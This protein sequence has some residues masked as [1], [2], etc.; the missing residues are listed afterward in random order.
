M[1]GGGGREHALV[2]ALRR[3]P[4]AP[5]VLCAPGSAGIAREGVRCLDVGTGDLEG[6]V[7][8]A[9]EEDCD[10]VVIGPE[11]PLVDGLVD[12]LADG[13]VRAFGPTGAA[14]RIE[15]SKAYAK[16]VMEAA[17][18]ATPGHVVLGDHEAALAAIEDAAYPLVLKADMLAGGKGVV[19]CAN[20]AEAG[21]ALDDFFGERR[22]GDTVVVLEEFVDGE[23]ISLLAL[24]DGERALPMA[25]ARDFKRIGDGDRGSNTGGMGSYSPVA[26]IDAERAEELARSV[27]QPVLDELRGRGTPYHGV[28]Y[29]G[30]M[31]TLG[32]PQVLEF[33]CRF[34]DPET[35][36]ILPRLRSDLLEL[37]EAAVRPGGLEGFE[38]EW[39]PDP[40]VTVV[41][42]SRGYPA[43]SSSG[44]RISGIDEAAAAPDVEVLHAGTADDGTGGYVT[45]GG[46]V[47]D[48]T[49]VGATLAEARSRAYAAADRIEF[50]GRQLRRDIAAEAGEPVGA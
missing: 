23:E 15:G 18:V 17:G 10:L 20:R 40:A 14:A 3:G 22:F 37:L 7:V 4:R 6:L 36:A 24:C 19:V 30:L 1:V 42:A 13:Q 39:S 33:N 29:A 38:L 43:T 28:L 25:P 9:R 21:S 35:Q 26:G 5:E 34:G 44:D 32:G 31:L 47:L 49:A 11:A 8:V 16:E 45:A 12:E 48:V 46:R 41:L 27:H 50:E 2:R